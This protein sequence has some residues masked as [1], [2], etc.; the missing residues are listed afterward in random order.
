MSAPYNGPWH[1]HDM[2]DRT[3]CDANGAAVAMTKTDEQARLI[4]AAPE[5]LAFIQDVAATCADCGGTGIWHMMLDETDFGQAP[6]SNQRPCPTC[7]RI[8]DL[9]SQATP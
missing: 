2:E 4:A 3:V 5:M 8:R 9:I 7:Q 6:G 1:L